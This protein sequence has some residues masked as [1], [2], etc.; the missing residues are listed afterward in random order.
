MTSPPRRR[1]DNEYGAYLHVPFCAH[2]CDYCAF[3]TWTDRGHLVDSYLAAVRAEIRSAVEAGLPELTSVFV[4]GGT[5]SLADPAALAAVLDD[6]STSAAAEITVVCNPES[7]TRSHIDSY[8]A[9]GVNRISLGVQSMVDSVLVE[10]GR[11]H[12]TRHVRSAVELARAGGITNI[13]LDVIYGARHESVAEWR[14]TLELVVALEP[15]HLS[16]YGLTVE[17][18]TP[19]AADPSRHPFDDD[20]AEKYDLAT[21]LLGAAG[22]EWYEI[23]NWAKPGRRCRHN[24]LYWSQGNYRGFGCAAH[25][26]EDGRRWW[27]VHTPERYIDL[28]DRGQSVVAGSEVLAAD[29]RR[30]EALQ[31]SLRTDRGVPAGALS[32]EDVVL[33]DGLVEHVADRVVLTPAGRLLANEV[34]VRLR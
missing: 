34:A 7:V 14:S 26:H 15:D 29:V 25:S 27:N 30:T 21:E 31:L 6:L 20:L 9:A 3:A 4:G 32:D 16:V 17:P 18:G 19:L 1:E 23:S 5:P 11:Q 10:L 28:V 22:F 33:L 13:N 24:R 2:K 12:D 8:R